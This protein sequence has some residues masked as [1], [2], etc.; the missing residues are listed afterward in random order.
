MI[1][2][3][4]LKE[5]SL[6][7]VAIFFI[8]SCVTTTAEVQQQPTAPTIQ[9]AATYTGP[10]ARISVARIKCK[11]AKCS[12][13]I[14]DGLRDML[15]SALFQTNKFVVLGGREEIEEIREEIDLGQSGYVREEQAPQAG[16]W[17]SADI[18]ILGAI[19]AFEPKASGIGVG[20]GGFKAPIL[21]GIGFGKDDAYIAMDLRIVDVR[22][23]RIVNTTVVEGK[24]SSFKIGGLGGGIIGNVALGGALGVY[25]NTPMEKAV[26]VLI[27]KAV[28]FI[29][30]QTPASYFRYSPQGQPVSSTPQ[31]PP[32][33]VSQPQ[34]P[35]PQQVSG[36]LKR[37]SVSFTPGTL[38]LFSEDFSSCEEIPK[39]VVIKNGKVE[40]V[41]LGGRKW[42]VNI[43]P[44][45]EVI[46]KLSLEGNIAVEFDFYATDYGDL[47]FVF[48]TEGKGEKLHIS[49]WS[50]EI[51]ISFPD[52]SQKLKKA[53]VKTIHHLAI[54]QK[55]ET[56]RVFL[57]GQ[58]IL[59]MPVDPVL[60]SRNR[61]GFT[62][63]QKGDIDRGRY[64]LISN[65]KITKY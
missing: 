15:I 40:C 3:I 50:G 43:T 65:I 25:K 27:N 16:G 33:M 38:L 14:G 53:P 19:T 48:G 8:T 17:E 31:Q 51:S 45:S 46:K 21:G 20:I 47:Y 18:I 54:Q 41:E 42:I 12:G 35:V 49:A 22:T 11:A 60:A 28:N 9:Q 7:I 58:R 44:Y 29:A 57:N 64:A 2:K 56:V 63:I 26:R 10:K 6:L 32:Q 62:I 30:S 34:Q 36:G 5:L 13:A 59:T 23:R 4:R 37:A 52:D 1:R 24:A 61:N 55:N 39:G